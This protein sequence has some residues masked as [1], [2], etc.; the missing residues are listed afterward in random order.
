MNKGGTMR[1]YAAEDVVWVPVEG[2]IVLFNA[3]EGQYYGLDDVGARIWTHVTEGASTDEVV[4]ALLEEF[5]VDRVA[6]QTEVERLLRELT[7]KH[8]LIKDE[9]HTSTASRWAPLPG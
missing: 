6:A 5:D 1:L 4:N 9:A 7:E 2:E 3:A 8:L